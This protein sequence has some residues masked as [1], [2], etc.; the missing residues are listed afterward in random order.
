MLQKMILPHNPDW[1]ISYAD[2]ADRL[3]EAFGG[4]MASIH[5]IGGT[6][7]AGQVTKPIID[8][9]VVLESFGDEADWSERLVDLGYDARGEYGIAGRRYFS[10]KLANEELHGFHVHAY[11]EGSPHIARHLAFRDYLRLHPKVA[12][13]YGDLKRSI[14]DEEG[15]LPDD[16]PARKAAFVERT[17]REALA[18]FEQGQT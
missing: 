3:K 1:K 13:D 9:L 17:E 6:S 18:H 11:V 2:E 16:Y 12:R 5:H 14:A 4:A 15:R 7:V 10:R 8:I